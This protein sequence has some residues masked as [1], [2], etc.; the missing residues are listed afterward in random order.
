MPETAHKPAE[1]TPTEVQKPISLGSQLKLNC[2]EIYR[3]FTYKIPALA[4][5]SAI[6]WVPHYYASEI[7]SFMRME[8]WPMSS[9]FAQA[10]AIHVVFLLAYVIVNGLYFVAYNLN[11]PFF[12]QYKCTNRPW[13]WQVSQKRWIKL[14]NRLIKFFAINVGLMVPLYMPIIGYLYPLSMKTGPTEMPGF[15]THLFHIFVMMACEDF[16]FYWIH[17][18]AHTK[19]LYK[20][21]HYVHHEY[22]QNVSICA[23]YAHPLEF[24]FADAFATLS[25]MYVCGSYCHIVTA[26]VFVML[27]IIETSEAHSGYEFP[28]SITNMLPFSVTSDYHDHH[29]HTNKGNFSTFFLFWDSICSTNNIYFKYL[30]KM[31]SGVKSSTVKTE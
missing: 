18:A 26:M 28:W 27:R 30:A 21:V 29:H 7:T 3:N 31:R 20:H 1:K 12:E 14:R 24:V 22:I 10:T 19:F 11:H 5:L 16:F 23:T 2:S 4:L 13:P 9:G 6:L 25:G 17:R 15:A 8:S